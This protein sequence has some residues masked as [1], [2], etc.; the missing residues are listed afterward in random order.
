MSLRPTSL[1][2][3]LQA[4]DGPCRPGPGLPVGPECFG[5]AGEKDAHRRKPLL[6]INDAVN[7]HRLHRTGF[8][9]REH[10]AAIVRRLRARRHLCQGHEVVNQPLD[11]GLTPAVPA[12]PTRDYVLHLGVE[13]LQK[14]DV[15]SIQWC[16]RSWVT[17]VRSA[18]AR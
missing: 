11:V 8:R 14:R 18:L 3:I 9:E 2:A 15:A 10:G 16:P 17:R 1:R 4:R 7:C 13:Q 6:P 5:D 12:L